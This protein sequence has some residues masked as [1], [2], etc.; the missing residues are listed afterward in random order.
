M[1]KQKSIKE[2]VKGYKDFLTYASAITGG[3]KTYSDFENLINYGISWCEDGDAVDGTRKTTLCAY[4][5]NFK[6][7]DAVWDELCKRPTLKLQVNGQ[8]LDATTFAYDGCHKIYIIETQKDAE[9]VLSSCYKVFPI[10]EL[11]AIWDISCELKF[12][13]NWSLSTSFVAQF[14]DAVFKWV[15]V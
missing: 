10:E 4:C 8:V 9:D 13:N 11:P 7:C 3:E 2:E 6:N 1:N 14:E 15:E 12:I 5:K